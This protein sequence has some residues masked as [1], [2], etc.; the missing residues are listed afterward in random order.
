M[1][2][3][4]AKFLLSGWMD[5]WV[6]RVNS[7]FFSSSSVF[8]LECRVRR[9]GKHSPSSAPSPMLLISL[10]SPTGPKTKKG[11]PGR[12]AGALPSLWSLSYQPKTLGSETH[13]S[14]CHSARSVS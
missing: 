10:T 11:N 5:G 7:Q 1:R 2:L 4:S 13:H 6:D 8:P 14:I 3:D 12:S 9:G